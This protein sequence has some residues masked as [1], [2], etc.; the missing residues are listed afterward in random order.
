MAL[1]VVEVTPTVSSGAAYTA[2]D[3]VGGLMT[4]EGAGPGLGEGTILQ[5][6]VVVDKDKQ[7]AALDLYF[8]DESPTVA[9]ADNEAANVTDAEMADK[10]IGHVAI[11]AADYKDLSGNSTA[12]V[13][14]LG[15]R[16]KPTKGGSTLYCVAVT[17]GTPTYTSTSALV[18][19]FACEWDAP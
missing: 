10:C 17:G 11:A 14:N 18:F 6:V 1:H 12:S 7:K 4:L 8:F 9:S 2:A 16:L 19:K 15:M 5:G 3:Q 13:R